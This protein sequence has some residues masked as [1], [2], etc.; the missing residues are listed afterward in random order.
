MFDRPVVF[1]LSLLL[2]LVP[3]DAAGAMPD[4]RTAADPMYPVSELEPSFVK[5]AD[6][7]VRLD[8]R[9]LTLKSREEAV[10]AVRRVVTVFTPEGREFGQ[11]SVHHDRFKDIASFDGVIRDA[12]GEVIRDM[13]DEDRHDVSLSRGSTIA[14]DSRLRYAQLSHSTYPYTVELEYKVD[15]EGYFILPTWQP[16][17]APSVPVVAA[18]FKVSTRDD[19][20][21]RHAVRN[22]EMDVETVRDGEEEHTIWS[23]AQIPSSSPVIYTRGWNHRAP[24][25]HLAPT[26]FTIDGRRGESH[27]WLDLGAW[28]R[29]LWANRTLLPPEL[30][31]KVDEVLAESRSTRETVRTLYTYMQDRTRYISVQL[32]LGGWK[33][34]SPE[35]VHE[36]GYGDCKA[37]TNYLWAMLD[38]A[39]I[40]AAPALIYRSPTPAPFLEDFPSNQFNHVVLTVPTEEDTLWIEATSKQLPFDQVHL[41]IADRPALLLTSDGGKLVRTPS[42]TAEDNVLS[43][44]TDIAVKANGNAQVVTTTHRTGAATYRLRHQ[45]ATWTPKEADRFAAG[46]YNVPNVRVTSVDVRGIDSRAKDLTYVIESRLPRF[47]SSMGSR[48][49]VPLSPIG[50]SRTVPPTAEPEREIPYYMSRYPRTIID[51]TTYRIPEGYVVEALPDSMTVE[52]AVSSL[53]ARVERTG[54]GFRQIRQIVY[55]T[56]DIPVEHYEN[57]RTLLKARVQHDRA[58]VVLVKE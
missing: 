56:T 43:R 53:A 23:M 47:A 36:R 57:H 12:S 21:Y 24:R 55:E 25:L 54:E 9:H 38:Y 30:K 13:D 40:D 58:Q 51:T 50:R 52:T 19:L 22:A 14:T 41:G 48:L 2:L 39:D 35:Y 27:S 3:N 34:F 5:G 6:A 18:E 10:Y 33:P 45:A 15:Y 8:K 32:G 20:P 26:R 31:R 49:F 28:Y 29:S 1:L 4:G 17:P 42:G 46:R 7:V 11:M 37:L 44:S 16:Q